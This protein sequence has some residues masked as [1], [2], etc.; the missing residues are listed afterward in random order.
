MAVLCDANKSELYIR[1]NCGCGNSFY[2]AL[3]A[4]NPNLM[5]LSVNNSNFSREQNGMFS[6]LRH[7]WKKIWCIIRN[8]DFC[9]SEMVLTQEEV[10]KLADYLHREGIQKFEAGMDEN[11]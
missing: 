7:K 8:K 5:S 1:C 4:Y 3:D 6:V 11:L 9:Y 10:E 2:F